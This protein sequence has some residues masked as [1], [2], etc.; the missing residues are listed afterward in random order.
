[1]VAGADSRNAPLQLFLAHIQHV[2]KCPPGL[3]TAS[4]LEELELQENFRAFAEFGFSPVTF[5]LPNGGHPYLIE[6][7]LVG[8]SYLANGRDLYFTHKPAMDGDCSLLFTLM[9]V[10]HKI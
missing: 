10:D 9:D 2:H 6:Y 8:G 4:V 1:M 3:K 7:F 5:P